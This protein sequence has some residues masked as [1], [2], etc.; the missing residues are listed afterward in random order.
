MK[1]A[2]FVLTSDFWTTLSRYEIHAWNRYSVPLIIILNHITSQHGGFVKSGAKTIISIAICRI[3]T[4]FMA[5]NTKRSVIIYRICPVLIP[6]QPHLDTTS[7]EQ[8]WPQMVAE[9]THIIETSPRWCL[10]LSWAHL[11][12]AAE[13]PLF[14]PTLCPRPDVY[15]HPS[16]YVKVACLFRTSNLTSSYPLLFNNKRWC[17]RY[18]HLF[19][20]FVWIFITKP[21]V[22]CAIQG[23]KRHLL[24]RETQ[25][26][27]KI[28]TGLIQFPPFCIFTTRPPFSISYNILILA[29]QFVSTIIMFLGIIN[30]PVFI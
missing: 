20:C 8:P 26:W 3:L 19:Y 21:Q 7:I 10:H 4:F 16:S 9:L 17:C 28:S 18:L 15:Q 13:V 24:S 30:R 12:V 14:D 6:W 11:E 1:S 29:P 23:L 5:I 2:V 25:S 27:Y 22:C